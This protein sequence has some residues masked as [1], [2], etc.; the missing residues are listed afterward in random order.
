MHSNNLQRIRDICSITIVRLTMYA[1]YIV[2]ENGVY[3]TY[4]TPAVTAVLFSTGVFLTPL[5][6]QS[7]C[8]LARTLLLY[9]AWCVV[10]S[11]ESE[12]IRRCLFPAHPHKGHRCYCCPADLRTRS[13]P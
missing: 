8:T 10:C 9:L 2:A 13:I 12:N 4:T 6:Y 1:D 3:A 5:A 11:A 7:C